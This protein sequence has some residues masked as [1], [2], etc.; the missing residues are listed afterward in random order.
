MMYTYNTFPTAKLIFLHL[1]LILVFTSIS[2]TKHKNRDVVKLNSDNQVLNAL[3]TIPIIPDPLNTV[4]LF[5]VDNSYILLVQNRNDSIFSVY[6]LPEL[7]FLYS[8]GQKGRGPD[9]FPNITFNSINVQGN[10]LL[11]YDNALKKVNYY[12]INDSQFLKV[13]EYDQVGSSLAPDNFLRAL[14]DSLFIAVSMANFDREYNLLKAGTPEPIGVI[15][16][17]PESTLKGVDLIQ[18]FDKLTTVNSEL[19]KIASYYVKHNS[20]RLYSYDGDLLKDVIIEDSMYAELNPG[21]IYRREL[22]SNDEYIFALALYEHP[23]DLRKANNNIKSTIEVWNW[24]G[25]FIQRNQ[26]DRLI[27][28]FIYDTNRNQVLGIS[29]DD[30]SNFYVYNLEIR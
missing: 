13:K 4:G 6:K 20:F 9:E 19:K 23:D 5:L 26:F 1:A 8:F 3:K 7:D 24:E 18:E 17:Y 28:K 22:F 14:D 27:H 16:N 10:N 11:V 21:T 2:C 25:D 30:P 15:G 12:E 29:V